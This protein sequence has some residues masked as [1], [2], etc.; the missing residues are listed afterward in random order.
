M[1]ATAIAATAATATVYD[2]SRHRQRTLRVCEEI[3]AGYAPSEDW[4]EVDAR[5][6]ELGRRRAAHEHEVCLALCDAERLEVPKRV[7]F[8]SLREYAERRL[9][10]NGRQTEE[11]LRVGHA[12]SR[13][14]ALDEALSTGQLYWSVVR[15]LSR[16]AVP[17]TEGQWR[18]WARGKGSRQVEK[19][20]ASRQPGDRP[21]DKPDPALIK[22]CL[23]FEV[24]AETMA[25]FRELQAAI[26]EEL[27]GDVD[28]DLLLYEIARRALGGTDDGGRAPYQ[29]AVTRCDTCE[30]VAIAAG[31]ES[32]PVDA[33]VEDMIACDAQLLPH[34]G[35]DNKRATQSVPPARRRA[36][37]RR[38]NAC[39]V[40]GCRNHRHLHVHHVQPRSEGGNHDPLL[41][42]PLCHRHHTACHAGA[43]VI[44]G[45]AERGFTFRH[46]D[47]AEYGQPL[48]PAAVDLATQTFD[49]LR[50]LG[51]KMTQARQLIDAVQHAGA[52]DT[53]EAFLHAALRST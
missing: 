38:D 24:R 29:V 15:E 22:H 7:G 45:N 21:S 10:L 42:V 2:L 25:L 30:L 51:F 3:S 50:A 31:G 19:A 16:I 44:S 39:A 6:T 5:I 14:P 4:K 48:N 36:V 32:H 53:L 18:E 47:G 33:V 52:P 27:G 40:P 37:L 11:R 23:R 28:D 20:V 9:G 26:R 43:L 17:E 49:A 46:A 8:A 13:L 35:A 12:L 1:Q 34:V 41:L